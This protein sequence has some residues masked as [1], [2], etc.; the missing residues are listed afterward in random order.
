[1]AG[2]RASFSVEEFPML[3]LDTRETTIMMRIVILLFEAIEIPLPWSSDSPPILRIF[4]TNDR[5]MSAAGM[6][7]NQCET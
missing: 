1:M 5:R 6:C 7:L 4:F 3:F 2:L